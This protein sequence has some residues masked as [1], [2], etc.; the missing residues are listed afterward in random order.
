MVQ[1]KK[2][3]V[4]SAAKI[5]AVIQGAFGLIAVPLFLLVGAMQFAQL[6]DTNRAMGSIFLIFAL[7]VPFF[8]AAIGFIMAAIVALIY[9]WFAGRFGG[10]KIELAGAQFPE[11]TVPSL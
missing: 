7:L 10:L 4:L 3:G 8:Y 1:L 11:T 5:G 2:V 6:P 9:N